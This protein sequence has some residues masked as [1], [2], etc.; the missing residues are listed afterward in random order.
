MLK[1]LRRNVSRLASKHSSCRRFHS[2]CKPLIQHTR[3][4]S[5]HN[6]HSSFNPIRHRHFSS[7]APASFT[8]P[9]YNFSAMTLPSAQERLSSFREQLKLNN[10]D[11]FIQSTCDA[12][13]S[14]YVCNRDKRLGYLSCFT[15][16]AGTIVITQK[17]ALLWTDGRYFLAANNEISDEW[18]LMKQGVGDTPSVQAWIK[19][20]VEGKVGIDP[21][22]TSISYYNRLKDSFNNQPHIVLLDKNPI[23]TIWGNNQPSIPSNK[24]F[25]HDIKYSGMSSQEKIKII[26]AKINENNVNGLIV[27]SLDHIAWVLNLRGNDII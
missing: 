16:S 5:I 26:Q 9:E 2:N 12:H 14:E 13:Q 27:T 4:L 11:C 25:I 7:K 8:H 21:Y 3:I 15:G 19:K 6:S 24:V 23:D 22:L 20:N 17:E 10:I 18:T 1:A